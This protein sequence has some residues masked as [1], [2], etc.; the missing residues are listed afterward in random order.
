MT[1]IAIPDRGQR[2]SDYVKLGEYPDGPLTSPIMVANG[3]K[4]GPRLFIQCLVHGPEVVGPIS[5]ARFI[6]GLDL[7]RLS[8]TIIAL[9]VANPFGFRARN[10]FTPEDGMNL[11]RVFPG[12]PSGTVSEQLAYNLLNMADT[13][14]DV[15]LDLHSGGDL[16]TTPFYAI[17]HK[18][19]TPES[20]ESAR[21]VA[22]TGSRFQW[23][24]NEAWMKGSAITNYTVQ[25][26]KPALIVESGGGSRVT[27][28]DFANFAR[29]L[30][31]VTTALG[32]LPGTVDDAQDIRRGGNAIHIKCTRGGFWHPAVMPGDD[33]KAGQLMGR[34]INMFG[35]LVEEV[36]CPIQSAWVGSVRRPYMPLFSGD[37]VM[38][39]VERLDD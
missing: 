1:E 9:L 33:L 26:K 14:G 12:S 19:D 13:N 23:A 7:S 36:V 6:K 27:E 10:R 22:A 16:S 37:Q 11:N 38:E 5:A 25:R 18:D 32:M 34:L 30:T 2:T 8:G 20:R 3:E 39:V 4:P 29:A 28:D 35:D 31:G 24:S 21:L 15:L 17:H